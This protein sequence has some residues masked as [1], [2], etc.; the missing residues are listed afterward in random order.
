MSSGS[1]KESTR[2]AIVLLVAGVVVCGLA[3]MLLSIDRLVARAIE[4]YGSEALGARVSVGAVSIGLVEGHGRIAGLRVAQ[5][6]GWGS[7]DALVLGEIVIDLDV[8]SLAVGDP[9]VLE[10]VQVADPVV[11]Y[12]VDEKGQSNLDVFR[13]RLSEDGAAEVAATGGDARDG[14][15]DDAHRLRI[16]RIEIEGGRILADVRAARVGARETKLP[17]L[18]IE[19]VGGREGLPPDELAVH[20]GRRLVTHSVVAVTASNVG[21]LVKD[22]GREVRG[23]L[24]RLIP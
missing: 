18:R 17:S 1:R 4:R 7:G 3:A 10:L 20:I 13:R 19:R 21:R 15:G 14:E 16:D 2:S 24:E 11:L 12:I 8:E 23:L 22:G 9:Y 6:E 5:P